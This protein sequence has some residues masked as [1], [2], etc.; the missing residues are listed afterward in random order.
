MMRTAKSVAMLA[1]LAALLAGQAGAAHIVV[2]SDIM[3]GA[4]VVWRNTNHY[5]LQSKVYVQPGATLIIE[6]G[7]V[8]ATTTGANQGSLV[9]CR[10]A[11]IFV[12]GTETDPVIFTSANDVATWAAD[13]THPTGKNPKSGTWREACNE[14]GSVAVL[15]RGYISASHYGGVAVNPSLLGA[16]N[17]KI[18]D[19]FN[20]KRMEGLVVGEG[21]RPAD[22]T[23]YGGNDDDDDSGA[24]HY[25][26]VR[27]AG[28]VLGLADE[29]NGLSMGGVGRETDV[30]HVEIMNN[31]DDGIETWGG[32]V[33][34]KYVSIW[35]VGD[36]SFDFDEGWRGKAQFGLIVQGYSIDAG[37][38]SG[39]GDNCFEHDGAEDSDAQPCTTACIYNFTTIGQFEGGDH[40]TA[41][42]DNARVQYHNCIW[43]TLGENLVQN[44]GTDGDGAQGYG[45]NGTLTWAATWTT[46]YTYYVDSY[47]TPNQGPILVGDVPAF[48][49]A[50]V[51]GNLAEI[52]DSII[53][54]CTYSSGAKDYDGLKKI[55]RDTTGGAIAAEVEVTAGKIMLLKADT[56]SGLV[57]E[58]TIDLNTM[59]LGT[60]VD[61]IGVN[62]TVGYANWSVLLAAPR[63]TAANLLKTTASSNC[64]GSTRK[65]IKYTTSITWHTTSDAVGVTVAGGSS[66]APNNN[67]VIPYVNG[68]ESPIAAIGYGANVIRG[69]LSMWPVVSLDPRA[70]NE[71]AEDR[72]LPPDDGFYTQVQYVGGFSPDVNWLLGWTASSAYGYHAGQTN[73]TVSEMTMEL[74]ASVLSFKT[75]A[76]VQYVIEESGTGHEWTQFA[77]VDGTGGIVNVADYGTV[78]GNK[79]YRVRPL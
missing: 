25:M 7:T 46:P 79:L 72:C 41:W 33:N 60:V 76:G 17:T 69:G 50:Q 65:N 19:G 57:T 68:S 53:Y 16:D 26:S 38:G 70:R 14:W 4:P 30:D 24:I 37:Q 22:W 36:D 3:P 43:M 71:A 9:V 6:P 67:L 18:P 31:V 40:G 35:N 2:N 42:R 28:E 1:V 39:V 62:K 21:G 20:Q 58:H 61:A 5:D 49:A 29:L 13:A 59:N 48:Y 73:P 44:D 64:L 27:Y 11:Q 15:G 51:S 75:T 12:N 34:Y 45:Y 66:G 55:N 74:K 10:G 32:A 8:I 47:P 23:R 56:G 77:I 52:K 78:E 63:D 54:D